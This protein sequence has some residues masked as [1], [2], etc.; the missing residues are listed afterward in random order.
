[1]EFVWNLYG[2]RMEF[3]WNNTVAPPALLLV[4]GDILSSA[5]TLVSGLNGETAWPRLTDTMTLPAN[6]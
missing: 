4:L 2:V 5:L 6:D 3:L 1:M